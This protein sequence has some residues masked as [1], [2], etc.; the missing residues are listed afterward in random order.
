MNKL[1]EAKEKG[2]IWNGYLICASNFS[3]AQAVGMELA[4]S[5]TSQPYVLEDVKM[6]DIRSMLEQANI[7]PDSGEKKVFVINADLMSERSQNAILKTLE[8]PPEFC[9]FILLCSNLM[10][11]LPTIKSRCVI[12]QC[13][14]DS[15]ERMLQVLQ[16]KQI[17]NPQLYLRFAFGSVER[18]I[19]LS[20]DSEFSEN[21]KRVLFFLQGYLKKQIHIISKEEKDFVND[22]IFYLLLFFKDVASFS[23]PYY[24]FDQSELVDKFRN[25]FTTDQIMGIIDIVKEK[26]QILH[27]NTNPQLVWDSLQVGLLEV[28]HG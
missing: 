20:S 10:I 17:I 27:K 6:E 19:Q 26:E 23:Q 13:E 28:I 9:V 24:F 8:D 21:R 3:K 12:H 22:Y 14:R 4:Y 7:K 15:E 2:F 1:I 16:E 5:I 18:A 25:T 11:P